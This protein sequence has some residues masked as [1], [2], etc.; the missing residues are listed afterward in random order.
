MRTCCNSQSAI[1][2]EGLEGGDTEIG[3]ISEVPLTPACTTVGNQRMN[4][5]SML[6][7]TIS[8]WAD[9]QVVTTVIGLL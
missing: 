2:D 1:K 9:G 8:I 4:A 3:L 6:D 7:E 5:T